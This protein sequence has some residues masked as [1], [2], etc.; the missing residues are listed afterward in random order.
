MADRLINLAQENARRKEAVLHKLNDNKRRE[1]EIEQL[2]KKREQQNQ[3]I[4][5]IQ[6]DQSSKRSPKKVTFVDEDD[7]QLRQ[8]RIRK[9]F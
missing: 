3:V 7:A 2:Q 5:K 6:K 1:R 9:K 8:L 4:E